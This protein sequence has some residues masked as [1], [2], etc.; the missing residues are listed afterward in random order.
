MDPVQI[1]LYEWILTRI[2][3]IERLRKF[4]IKERRTSRFAVMDNRQKKKERKL[5]AK[6]VYK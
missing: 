1:S 6:F 5:V 2:L 4:T 3:N